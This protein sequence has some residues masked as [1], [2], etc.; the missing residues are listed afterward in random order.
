MTGDITQQFQSV[1]RKLALRSRWG[2]QLP[3]SGL[4]MLDRRARRVRFSGGFKYHALADA[5]QGRTASC[6]L[7]QQD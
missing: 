6:R 2:A 3:R 7:R 5:A 4:R 1:A